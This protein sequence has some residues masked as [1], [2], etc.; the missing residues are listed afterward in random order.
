MH[1]ETLLSPA[2]LPGL[3]RRPLGQ[4]VC[5]VFDILRAT[6][7]FV[8]ALH[9]GAARIIPVSDIAEAVT[10]RKADAAILL[11]GERD[12]VRIQAAQSGAMDF[13]LGNSPREFTPE[14]IRGRTIVS[15]TTNGTR[16]LRACT[17]AATVL[18]G[19]FLNLEATA[20]FLRDQPLSE[21]WLI[22]AGTGEAAADEDILAAGAI[23]DQ[24]RRLKTP[25]PILSPASQTALHAYE[26]AQ[27]HL[28]AALGRAQNGR[29]LLGL[30]ELRDDVA[31]CAQVNRFPLVAMLDAH[32]ALVKMPQ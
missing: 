13:D 19:S 15:T 26:S 21:V 4:S 9:H 22:C 12:G 31:Y 23:I 6:S 29:R 7:T 8:T 10:Y 20:R 14:K 24:L 3:A 17:S 1:I 32:G 27:A 18:A 11:A 28:P 16:A 25:A 30:P 2:D 5:V